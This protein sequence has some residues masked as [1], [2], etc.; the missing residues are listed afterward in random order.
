MLAATQ[1]FSTR[2]DNRMKLAE[3]AAETAASEG[4][5]FTRDIETFCRLNPDWDLTLAAYPTQPE[6]L[7]ATYNCK[8]IRPLIATLASYFQ[9]A[10][11]RVLRAGNFVD[12]TWRLGLPITLFVAQGRQLIAAD[13]KLSDDQR[14][15]L[16]TRIGYFLD[17]FESPIRVVQSQQDNLALTTFL[18]ELSRFWGIPVAASL[19]LG[20]VKLSGDRRIE[21]SKEVTPTPDLQD[22]LPPPAASDSK[23]WSAEGPSAPS[24]STLPQNASNDTFAANTLAEE[25]VSERESTSISGES[26]SLR[27]E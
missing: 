6:S 4:I 18:V 3:V 24:R 26:S 27:Q 20:M 1:F 17:R 22:R 11:L 23:T 14:E 8:Q 7:T 19:A 16:D 21:R 5:R 10:R 25:K 9:A 15:V 2:V 13:M 12:P